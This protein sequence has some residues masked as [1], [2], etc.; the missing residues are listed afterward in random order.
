[1]KRSDKIC[2]HFFLL[3]LFYCSDAFAEQIGV[4]MSLP[5][6][7][8]SKDE[9][10]KEEPALFVPD[11]LATLTSDAN[12]LI[13]GVISPLS[14]NPC[15]R[16][17]DFIVAGAQEIVLS[18]VYIA[19]YMP[20]NFH[21]H[22]DADCYYRR[23]Y[24]SRHYEGWKHF[25]HLRLWVDPQK[26]EVHLTNSN[27]A[28][29]DFSLANGKTTL[30]QPYAASNVGDLEIP[31]G[32]FDP[33][34]TRITYDGKNATVFSPDGSTRHYAFKSGS[35]RALLLEKEILPNGKILRYQYSNGKLST[36]ESLDPKERYIYASIN[37]QGIPDAGDCKFTCSTGL[38]SSCHFEKWYYSD[39]FR[40]KGHKITYSGYTPPLMTGA[41][42]PQYRR[43]TA[44]YTSLHC[45]LESFSGKEKIFSV[46]QTAFG[47]GDKV[48]FRVDKLLLPVGQKDDFLPVYQMTYQP[49]VAG[50]KE[51][52]TTVKNANGT[53]TIYHFSKNLLTTLIQNF[54]QD[55]SL[56][57]EKIF[58]WN[59]K[60]WLTSIEVRDGNKHRFFQ[61]SYEYDG[62][63]NPIIE[64]FTGDLQGTGSEE[65]Y[66]I[67]REFSQDGRNLL[68]KEETEEGKITIFEYLPNTNLVTLKLIK[69]RDHLLVR[70]SFQ[71]DD[72]HNL[73]RKSTDDGNSQ[74]MITGYILRQQQPFLHMPEWIEEKYLDN[75]IERLLKRTHLTYDQWGHV[76]E[77]KVHD[78]NV[79][80]AYSILKEYNE[81][82]DLLSETNPFGQKH[83][84]AY[85][86][87][88][89][90]IESTNF[91]QRLKEEM[92]YD[93]KGRLREY[94]A[95]GTDGVE[96][97]AT[98]TYDGNDDLIQKTDTYLNTF[99]YAHDPLT[100][101]IVK[102]TLPSILSEDG[103]AIVVSESST[104]DAQG[105]QTSK[106]DANGNTT[107]YRYNAYSLPIEITYPNG[108]KEFYC[109]TKSGKLASHTDR[110]GLT[111]VYTVDVLGRVTAKD[112]GKTLG[113][114]SCVYDSFNL[115][116]ETDLEGNSTRYFYD[117]AK[118]KIR[119]ES[120]GRITEFAYDPLGW[121]SSISKEGLRTHFERDL[122]GRILEESKIDAVGNL[123]YKIGYSYNEDG[124]IASI[125]RFIDGKEA[126]ESLAYDSVGRKIEHQDPYGNRTTTIYDENHVN[127]LGQQALQ[128][129]TI[130]PKGVTTIE[131]KD[132]FL[133]I[134][135]EEIKSPQGIAIAS[136]DKIYDPNGNVTYWKEH[137]Y[138]DG[139]YK[140]TQCTYFTYTSD[141]NV[142]S[143]TCA[144]GSTAA[145]TTSNTYTPDGKVATKA[146]SD[147]T[148]LVYDYDLLGFLRN[149]K[150]SDGKIRHRFE[151]NKNGDLLSAFDEVDNIK[152]QREVDP[153]G[154]VT[155][156]LFPNRIE[157][158][159]DYDA[160]DRLTALHI[161]NFG[162]VAYTYDSL[163]LRKVSRIA[164]DG[165][166]QY[167]HQYESYDLD[168]NLLAE[169]MISSCGKIRH[170][171]DLKGR[172]TEIS[173]PY[174]SQKC[175]YD[176][177]D[178]LI[179]SAIDQTPI[180]YTYD[181]LYQLSSENGEAYKYDSLF[182]RKEKGDQHF[183]YNNLNQLEGQ[184]Y[185]LNGNQI[186]K[187]ETHYAYD[188]LNRLTE[189]TFGK[190]RIHFLYDPLGRRLTKVVMDKM[191]AG[192][193]EIYRENYL[194]DGEQEIGALAADGTLKN[195][196]VLGVSKRKDCP[197]TVA[198]ELNNKVF[199]P[200]IDVQGNIR[201]LV[202]PFSK[203][204]AKEYE[205]TAFGEGN[206]RIKDENPWRYAAKR[207][208]PELNL[209]YFGKRYYDPELARWLTT[210]PA[211]FQD[212]INLY[213]YAFN[214][215]Y[216]YYDPNGEFLCFIT[217]PLS[218]LLNPVVWKIA[219]DAV[220]LSI[221]SWGLY[222]GMEYATDAIGSPC[223][224][225]ESGCNVLLAQTFDNQKDLDEKSSKKKKKDVTTNT[226][227]KP[228]Y[229]GRDLGE[230]P[231]RC[232]GEGFEWKGRGPPGSGKGSWHNEQTKEKLY[233]DLDHPP[234]K[235]P[236]W[237]YYSPEFPKGT[238]LNTDGTWEP[239]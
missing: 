198:I 115:I 126:I 83:T 1:M 143:N 217:I 10:K 74:K 215:P 216:C 149:F 70:E 39:K 106:K 29:Y 53:S 175:L 187:D 196:R 186:Q 62:Y 131:T 153:F 18:R 237:D 109:Y 27:A 19:P 155:R 69:D 207:F 146:L 174:F 125:R 113:R 161:S 147:G 85:D 141:N 44:T 176:A 118:R 21:K 71:F 163:F 157:I 35:G 197:E 133:R 88:G 8:C 36:V 111:T 80:Y 99:S 52:K 121:V 33:K 30:A 23:N 164:S 206:E 57:K 120:N 150:S 31:S 110:A 238:R 17:T 209:I 54:S 49:A 98:Y 2:G 81:R 156:E 192:W 79:K 51:G 73:I 179:Q 20:Y 3:C 7:I 9:S 180:S 234:P 129:T 137:L 225:S 169:N 95:T 105:R 188:P 142:E 203:K 220:A 6:Y 136:W 160:F 184:L 224:L 48:H 94:K 177:C 219:V 64:A 127:D 202:D 93:K 72:C 214:N 90:C 152:I 128:V 28:T 84:F 14:G 231:T 208:D 56:K 178:N 135:K 4:D 233:P 22:W 34:N 167:A 235:K 173:S 91:S 218:L 168:G 43:E 132:P 191:P 190:K 227:K 67:K 229:D 117:G 40:D 124:D 5:T 86:D 26:N 47:E 108:S 223:T 55:G 185:D 102:S 100:H 59:D 66:K 172:K 65:S 170:S 16:E 194:Y 232:P 25:P 50:E 92:H 201:K 165:K 140:N 41:A 15:L 239:K 89:H 226:G 24:L 76:A 158:K 148:V 222:K 101:K 134:V 38:N 77:E 37:M 193:E 182:N 13:G 45:L 58:S 42:S 212:S 195:L 213:Q 236:H 119:E 96:H 230:D 78:A 171:N 12:Q 116:E 123:L 130:D 60:G 103:S 221:G 151:Y 166:L 112:Y 210:D 46:N 122:E 145:R 32:R 205:F 63:G 162:S 159:K 200:A 104:Y 189:A 68:V 181:D 144:F 97:T 204:V 87:K 114:K 61:K 139:H 107:F 154:N 11:Q 75:G 228:R 82:G 211:G 138:E 183:K 199:A